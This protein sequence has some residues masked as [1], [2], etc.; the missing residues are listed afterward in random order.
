M[1]P[2]L[3]KWDTPHKTPPFTLIS[4]EHFKPAVE[5]SIQDASEEIRLI[6]ENSDPPTFKNT[7]EALERSGENLTRISTL[8]FNL[9]NAET[10]RELQKTTQEISPLLTRF[11][12]DITLNVKLF[13]RIKA[14]FQSQQKR[15]LS[16]E[17]QILLERK[18]RSF[19]LGGAEL[20]T[21]DKKRFRKLSEELSR[22]CLKF[23]ENVLE[24]T[25][26]FELHLTEK[27]D[28][29][30][31]PAG[32]IKMASEEAATRHKKG[33]IFT[34]NAPSF[35]PFLQYS[36]KREL[37]EKILKA[38][39]SR[40]F[41]GNNN[42]N[43]NLVKKIVN[44]RLKIA[45]MLGFSNYAEMVLEDR[46]VETREK[47]ESFLEEI[48]NSSHPAALRDFDNLRSF[49]AD[50]GHNQSIERWDWFFFAEKLKRSKYNID[51]E[52]LK[53]Y[54]SLESVQKAIFN[55]ATILY[56]LE[57]KEVDNIPV[58]HPEVRTWEV[59]DSDG[60]FMAVLYIDFHPRPGKNGGAWMT[61]YREQKTDNGHD[62]RPLVSIVT[63][64]SRSTKGQPS[65]LTFN[66][67]T[68]FLHEFGHALHS[69]LS[70][71]N[72]ESISGTNVT[73][74]FVELPSQLMEN[75]AYEKE[76]L[77]KWAI[78]Y[79]TGKK[80]PETYI[81]R[82]KESS[83]FNEGYAC[84]RQLGFGFLDMAWH[85]LRKPFTGEA[86]LLESEVMKK[87][88]LFPEITTAN[89]SCSFTHLFGGSYAAGYYGYKWAEVLDA[90]AFSLF[91]EKGIF[92]RQ[93]ADSF[94]KNILEKG[95]SDKPDILYKNFRGKKPTIDAFLE[96][97]GL[98]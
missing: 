36:E 51:D 11:S 20:G 18:Y 47:V 79:K 1:N 27:S 98:K 52:T 28:L 70:R 37:R 74:D 84:D 6:A 75:W 78:H 45:N 2:L 9:N 4:V 72:Y 12:N 53:P 57:F 35:T 55:L 71:C 88:N 65:L 29:A 60:S 19:I 96:R 46:M 39:T 14:V 67:L 85:S 63:N 23:E 30:G 93:V 77:D 94:R 69:I 16:K 17:K 32:I 87:I 91:R 22:L 92:N 73:R 33:W 34:L 64:F 31:L 56:G 97:S 61:C 40:A 25:N 7:V 80:I 42:D 41:N 50:H 21:E 82:I 43:R 24:E 66:E 89:I 54:L 68:T 86:A 62:I 38:Y 3:Q 90:D 26:S 13:K 58:Y 8:L 83:T 5:E 49:A 81:K 48:Y 15:N 76:W 44:L 10:S 95:Y 59:I